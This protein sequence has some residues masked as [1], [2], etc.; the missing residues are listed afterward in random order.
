MASVLAIA[1][2]VINM[3]KTINEML[4]DVKHNKNKCR[5]VSERV[6]ILSEVV[7]QI[8][9]KPDPLFEQ[10]LRRVEDLICKVK[11]FVERHGSMGR[12]KQFLRA[13]ALKEDFVELNRDLNAATAGTVF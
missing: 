12:V 7:V 8:K 11:Q 13:R 1:S 9:S 4:G 5:I 3:A 10:P 6:Q 2:N